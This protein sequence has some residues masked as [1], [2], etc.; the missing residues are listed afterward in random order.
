M[1]KLLIADDNED[2]LELMDLFLEEK[3]FEVKTVAT[4]KKL[5]SEL[6][7]YKPDLVLLDVFLNGE[8]GR[9][10]CKQLREN[11]KTNKL[12]III[13]SAN[14]YAM[15]DFKTFGADGYIEKPFELEDLLSKIEEMITT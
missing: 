2:L 10:I 8:D 7:N 13:I 1:A 15:K 6:K 12:C 4:R 3:G 14:P 9:E 11:V 5:F